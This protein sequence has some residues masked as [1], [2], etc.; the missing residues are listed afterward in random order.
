[1]PFN[2]KVSFNPGKNEDTGDFELTLDTFEI[3]LTDIK[4]TGDSGEI[5]KYIDLVINYIKEGLMA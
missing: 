1:M 5:M 3:D 2:F 4:I